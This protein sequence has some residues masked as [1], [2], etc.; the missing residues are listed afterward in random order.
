M[1]ISIG[2][3]AAITVLLSIISLSSSTADTTTEPIN[4]T[5]DEETINRVE[6]LDNQSASQPGS[7]PSPFVE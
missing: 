5:F 6:Q 2:L 7:R 1:L 4:G 3:F